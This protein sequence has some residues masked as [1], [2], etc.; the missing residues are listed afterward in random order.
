MA[1][2]FYYKDGIPLK[3]Y[4]N[5]NKIS[6]CKI[7]A[8]IKNLK[9]TMPNLDGQK[10][11]EKAINEFIDPRCR[12]FYNGVSLNQ[13]CKEHH[14]NY[15]II[16]RKI[17]N[18]TSQKEIENIINVYI[19]NNS[20]IS[21]SSYKIDGLSLRQYAQVHN[22]VYPTIKTYV[23]EIRKKYPDKS[24]NEIVL[25]AIKH[26]EEKHVFKEL[27]FYKGERLVDYCKKNDL[28]YSAIFSYLNHMNIKDSQNIPEE[29]MEIAIK[30]YYIKIRKDAFEKLKFCQEEEEFKGITKLLNIDWV[31]VKLVMSFNFNYLKAI[32][33][34]WY[35]GKEKDALIY[36][37]KALKLTEN[38]KN[39]AKKIT[40][41]YN[42]KNYNN[43]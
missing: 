24:D 33:F 4:C 32:Y 18:K 39:L 19:K 3:K 38:N 6:Y 30:K 7:I 25:L 40:E 12:Y 28:S 15:N 20:K 11:V 1:K 21:K 43:K 26:Y 27:W 14:L 23:Q 42:N 35:F 16:R 9:V 22:Y 34:V 2:N 5:D 8:R 31:S 41:F 29:A 10:L 36:Y 13:Y 17:I 37:N